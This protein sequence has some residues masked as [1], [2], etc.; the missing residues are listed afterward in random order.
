MANDGISSNFILYNK[1]ISRKMENK[2][3]KMRVFQII[4]MIILVIAVS[5][6]FIKIN[7]LD[8][9]ITELERRTELRVLPIQ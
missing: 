4:V 7:K 1:C 8:N 9:R 5:L 2:I 3:I 6:L